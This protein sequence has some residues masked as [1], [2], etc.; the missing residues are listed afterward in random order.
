MKN[1]D[2]GTI[3]FIGIVLII[4]MLLCVIII[5]DQ[6]RLTWWSEDGCNKSKSEQDKNGPMLWASYLA[7]GLIVII[8]LI[9]GVLMLG[10]DI[11]IYM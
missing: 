10:S 6:L 5:L 2:I 3:I 4:I 9:I 11:F 8:V 1:Q 7:R